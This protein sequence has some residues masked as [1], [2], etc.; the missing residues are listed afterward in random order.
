M[1]KLGVPMRFV[2]RK[3]VLVLKHVITDIVV[4]TA[5]CE[6]DAHQNK[7]SAKNSIAP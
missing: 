7:K 2:V 6:A 4:G 1:Q 5:K 3:S